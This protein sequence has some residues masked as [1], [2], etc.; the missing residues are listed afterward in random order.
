MN[1]IPLRIEGEAFS[2]LRLDF[3]MALENLL[4]EMQEKESDEADISVKLEIKLE[5]GEMPDEESIDGMPK[6]VVI[7]SIKH[8]VVARMV[9]KDE[10]ANIACPPATYELVWN[11]A[12]HGYDLVSLDSQCTLLD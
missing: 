8:K 7:P 4:S 2:N 12:T 3:N 9:L 6:R 11:K 5:D 10:R 1:R